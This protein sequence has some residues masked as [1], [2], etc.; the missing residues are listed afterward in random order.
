MITRPGCS[1]RAWAIS[2]GISH[3][4]NMHE[5]EITTVWGA[6]TSPKSVRVR[7]H[8]LAGWEPLLN[9][10]FS[11][12]KSAERSTTVRRAHHLVPAC[13]MRTSLWRRRG[14]TSS[15]T[16]KAWS[17]RRFTSAPPLIFIGEIIYFY[18]ATDD[19]EES[20]PKKQ[21]AQLLKWRRRWFTPDSDKMAE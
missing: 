20:E 21:L 10:C 15:K 4:S 12:Q 3:H 5:W 7:W 2:S 18:A 13:D 19:R 16:C 17:M 6:I 1:Q 11:P 9:E 8:Y 14:L